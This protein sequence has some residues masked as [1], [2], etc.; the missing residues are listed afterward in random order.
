MKH[1]D[2]LRDESYEKQKA[3]AFRCCD[4][5]FQKFINSEI[6]YNYG[7]NDCQAEMMKVVEDLSEALEQIAE[8]PEL[9]RTLVGVSVQQFAIQAIAK[10]RELEGG[11]SNES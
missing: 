5:C 1:L 11:E 9:S 2:K 4:S 7:W 8:Y 10:L 6:Y 3:E